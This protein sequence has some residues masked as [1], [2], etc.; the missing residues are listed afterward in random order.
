M[1]DSLLV[2]F[3]EGLESFLIIGIVIAYLRKT[4]RQPLIRGVYA[5]LVLSALTCLGGV[6][7][8]LRLQQQVTD[9]ESGVN[10][11]LYEGVGTLAAALLVALLLWQTLRAGRR[12][13]GDIEARM[14]RVVGGDGSSP[15]WRG[16]VGVTLATTLLVTRELLEAALFLWARA[17]GLRAADLALAAVLGL[18]LAGVVAWTWTRFANRLNLG[19]VLK[20]SAVFLGV[21]L[22]QLVV[23]GVH[24]LAESGVIKGSQAFHD[25]TE[26]LGP[27]GRIGHLISYSLLGAPLLYL[28]WARRLKATRRPTPPATVS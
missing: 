23:Y 25:A 14:S 9:A 6:W 2:T 22:L 5:G 13:K 12:I 20:V 28:F 27:D 18:V 11:A 8:W 1:L 17:F 3:R 19:V 10:Q 24:E 16:L 15:T 7:L 21:F 4:G 26:I